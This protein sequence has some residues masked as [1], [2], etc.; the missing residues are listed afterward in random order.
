MNFSI[1]QNSFVS[2][3]VYDILGREVKTLIDQ[4]MTAGSH[5]V[6]WNADNNL[7]GKVSTGMY[8]YRITAGSFVATKKMSFIK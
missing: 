5:S 1:P 6:E 8:I 3:R 2:I 4:Q 7:G